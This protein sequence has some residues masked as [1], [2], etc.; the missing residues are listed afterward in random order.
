TILLL[1]TSFQ[2]KSET[3]DLNIYGSLL[4]TPSLVEFSLEYRLF[5]INLFG[6]NTDTFVKSGTAMFGVQG[7]SVQY[8]TPIIGFIQYFGKL[9]GADL[10]VSYFNQYS[11]GTNNYQVERITHDE[12]DEN[13]RLEAGYRS[14]FSENGIFRFSFVSVLEF[15]EMKRELTISERYSYI[16]SF[17]VGYSF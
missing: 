11:V 4:S 16:I 7:A 3:R 13:I 15:D 12:T 6:L 14:Y 1:F 5:S 8:S 10:G 9:E 2:A 17:S